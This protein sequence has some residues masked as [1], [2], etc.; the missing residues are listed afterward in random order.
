M[1]ENSYYTLMGH[2]V[3]CPAWHVK[4]TLDGK[5]RLFNE[6]GKE[7]E[8]YF[9]SATCPIIENSKLPLYKQ[10]PEYKLMR[11]PNPDNCNYLKEFAPRVDV[12]TGQPL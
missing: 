12:R 4:V 1:Y 2:T 3:T 5:Y 7:Y 11:C 6:Q 9:A 8:G 10:R